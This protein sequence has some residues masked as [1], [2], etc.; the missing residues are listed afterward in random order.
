MKLAI[1]MAY[2][3]IATSNQEIL[4]VDVLLAES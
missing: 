1:D 4:A 2:E 3:F